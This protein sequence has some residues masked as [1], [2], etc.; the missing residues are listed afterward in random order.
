MTIALK[1]LKAV[2]GD[3]WQH[4]PGTIQIYSAI[5]YLPAVSDTIIVKDI[6]FKKPANEDFDRYLCKEGIN[7]TLFAP[8]VAFTI[9][10]RPTW[11]IRRWFF[12]WRATIFATLQQKIT[13][14]TF[15]LFSA[16]FLGNKQATKTDLEKQKEQFQTWGV[17]HQLARSGLHLIMFI[18][19]WELMLSL[20]PLSFALRQVILTIISIVYFLLSWSSLGFLR[21]LCMLFLYKFC[22]LMR[23]PINGVHALTVICFTMLLFNP[24]QLFF[25]NFQLNFALTFALAWFNQLRTQ[26]KRPFI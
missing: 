19:V 23:E 24:L 3:Q 26:Q 20:L 6:A 13:P 17:S 12:D 16:L 22:I 4:C 14:R 1:Q 9:V 18:L 7:A 21:A 8:K 11:S 10:A 25:L 15:S 2:P 5:T